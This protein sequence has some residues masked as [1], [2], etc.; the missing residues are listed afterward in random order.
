MLDALKSS[1]TAD[2]KNIVADADSSLGEKIGAKVKIENAIENTQT[3]LSSAVNSLK[4]GDITGAKDIAEGIIEG[5]GKNGETIREYSGMAAFSKVFEPISQDG[6]SLE[7]LVK[8]FGN[9][10]KFIFGF[11]KFQEVLGKIDEVKNQASDVVSTLEAGKEDI[12]GAFTSAQEAFSEFKKIPGNKNPEA[13]NAAARKFWESFKKLEAFKDKL[14][15]EQKQWLETAENEPPFNALGILKDKEKRDK[16]IESQVG[17]VCKNLGDEFYA[18]G[19][20]SVE[21]VE[22]VRKALQNMDFGADVV[23]KIRARFDDPTNPVAFSAADPANLLT[24]IL[25]GNFQMFGMLLSVIPTHRIIWNVTKK[26][27]SEGAE[28]YEYNASVVFDK[29]R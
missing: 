24:E 10:F 4:K 22:K 1:L 13:Y 12:N 8:C 14:T 29:I 25:C 27:A 18:G 20:L 5:V 19:D 7:N 21:Q 2:E 16:W 26:A 11:G 3:A 6:F 17:P 15:P 9:L 23:E 28:M